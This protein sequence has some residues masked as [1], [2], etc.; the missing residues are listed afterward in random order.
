MALVH[1]M[2]AAAAMIS[3]AVC[4]YLC[5]DDLASKCW[6]DSFEFSH[7]CKMLDLDAREFRKTIAEAHA[8]GKPLVPNTEPCHTVQY[9][10]ILN[11]HRTC[12]SKKV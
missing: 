10:Q 4:R 11:C 2:E 5:D 6:I 8:I 1:P 12:P 7:C 3:Q 9:A